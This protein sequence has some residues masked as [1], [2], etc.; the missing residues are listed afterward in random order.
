MDGLSNNTSTALLREFSIKSAKRVLPG[1]FVSSLWVLWVKINDEKLPFYKLLARDHSLC[2]Y[3]IWPTPESSRKSIKMI[4]PYSQDPGDS[5]VTYFYLNNKNPTMAQFYISLV[6]FLLGVC[7]KLW[8]TNE[9]CTEYNEE[10]LPMTVEVYNFASNTSSYE[11]EAIVYIFLEIP[12][13]HW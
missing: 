9:I 6:A 8:N 12:M 10:V 7:F 5:T 11:W 13:C 2:S 3:Q 4:L 1:M